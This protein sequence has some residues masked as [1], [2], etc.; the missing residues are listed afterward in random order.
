MTPPPPDS[1]QYLAHLTRRHFLSRCSIGLGGIALA[2]LLG[3][4]RALGAEAP[5][6]NGALRHDGLHQIGRAHV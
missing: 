4:R 5:L 1:A 6:P 2:S 3:N